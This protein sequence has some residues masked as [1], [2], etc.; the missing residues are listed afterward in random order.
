MEIHNTTEDLVIAEVNAICNSLEQGGKDSSVCTCGQCRQDAVC[1]VLNRTAPHYVVSHRGAARAGSENIASQQ[2]RADI[3]ALAYEGIKRVSHNQR[4]YFSHNKNDE[5]LANDSPVFNIPTIMGRIFNGLNFSPAADVTVELLQNGNIAAMRD[6]NWQN[7][8]R[9]LANT[10]GTF[11]FWPKPVKAEKADLHGIF[12]YSVR[13][14][15]PEFEDLNHGFTIPVKSELIGS[16]SFSL[17][18]TFKLPDLYLF[19]P[20]EEAGQLV[21]AED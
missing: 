12:E 17:E 7:P 13:I 10:N 6:N 1:Y 20:G 9:L 2:N 4:P 11:I 8:F 14:K 18:R 3:A 15:S 16:N 21:V 5:A 19:P